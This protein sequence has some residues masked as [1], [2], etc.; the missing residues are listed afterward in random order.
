MTN[1]SDTSLTVA[2]ARIAWVLDNPRMSPWLKA[3]LRDALEQDPF[4]VGSDVQ[5]LS[6]LLTGRADAWMRDQLQ[7]VA[8]PKSQP[9]LQLVRTAGA[10]R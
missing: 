1:P 8:P 2:E 7:A 6:H 3:A 9:Q 10:R 5:L 4:T